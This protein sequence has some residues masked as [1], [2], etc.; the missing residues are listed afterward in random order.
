MNTIPSTDLPDRGIAGLHS[1][2]E[3][4]HAAA[5]EKSREQYGSI[6][7]RVGHI[8]PLA[9]LQ[10]VYDPRQL[11]A[12]FERVSDSEAV[13]AA[14]PIALHVGEGPDAIK[15]AKVF[16]DEVLDN[17]FITGDTESL[18]SGPCFFCQFNFNPGEAEKYPGFPGVQ[19]YLPRWQVSKNSECYTAVA[20]FVVRPEDKPDEIVG[21]IWG[22]YKKFSDFDYIV[23]GIEGVPEDKV[24]PEFIESSD[25]NVTPIFAKAIDAIKRNEFTKLVVARVMDWAIDGGY[26]KFHHLHRLREQFHGCSI[27]S[28]GDA[29]GGAFIGATPER[30]LRIE[31][32]KLYTEALAGTAARGENA[33][34]DALMARDLLDSVKNH[35]EHDIVLAYLLKQLEGLGFEPVAGGAPRLKQFR[36]VQHLHTPIEAD[37]SRETHILDVAARIHP[38]PAV[39]GLP[40]EGSIDWLNEHEGLVRG[41]YAG[42]L[43][44]FNAA[45]EGELIVGIRSAL[46]QN[47]RIRLFAGAGIVEGSDPAKEL[48]ETDLKIRAISD[49]LL[50]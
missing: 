16:T 18:W 35:H 38:T 37:V 20:N 49:T 27:F 4:C 28:W 15:R 10:T 40:L 5:C 29:R 21:E 31:G 36:N 44:C 47:S 6:S 22:I 42:C 13:A 45:G 24:Q 32:G 25:A 30:L 43:G 17:T 7:L 46:V 26:N 1:F 12:Y 3:M 39:A 2:I 11:H 33:R 23:D 14:E 8:S 41:P 9:V 50:G 34:E 48:R 19:V